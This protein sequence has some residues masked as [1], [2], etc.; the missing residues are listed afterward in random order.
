[1]PSK[2]EEAFMVFISEGDW[3]NAALHEN[4][5]SQK[6]IYETILNSIEEGVTLINSD[7]ICIYCNSAAEKIEGLA[8]E[9]RLGRTLKEIYP[10]YWPSSLQARVIKT[11]TPRL[12]IHQNYTMG[13]RTIEV[14]SNTYPFIFENRM[15][16]AVSIF[17][18]FS[19][20]KKLIEQNIDL[21]YQLS[22]TSGKKNSREKANTSCQFLDIIGQS[23]PMISVIQKARRI[24]GTDSPVLIYG[25]T[26]TGKELFARSIHN[27]GPN[28]E[29]PFL[30]INCAAIPENLL[31][32]LLFGTTKGAF[33]GSMD[34]PGLFEQANG[35]SLFLD[36]IN[37]MP[38]STQSKLLRALQ[39]KRV[40]RLGQKNET[41]I[42]ARVISSCNIN[43]QKAIKTHLIRSDLFY[44]LA[45]VYLEIPPLKDRERDIFMLSDYFVKFFNRKFNKQILSLGPE[46]IKAF[47]EYDWPGNVRQLRHGIESAMNIVPEGAVF[48]EACHIPEYMGLFASQGAQKNTLSS[49]KPVPFKTFGPEPESDPIVHMVK[50]ESI[51]QNL[52][53]KEKEMII[54]SLKQHKGRIT[55]SAKSLGISRQSLQYRL[56]KYGIKNLPAYLKYS[57][58][59]MKP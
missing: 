9:D 44:R 11:Q 35:G 58:R 41:P 56:K 2:N 18:N 3:V 52:Q 32:S 4:I 19:T 27:A 57:E 25:E 53:D 47:R 59:L 33:T 1:M 40:R 5:T 54:K 50:D 26:G 6:K 49:P 31:E 45:V 7:G 46:V 12:N 10:L 14:I 34:K 51:L 23:R 28:P 13:N 42:D 30:A 38:M 8:K 43:P 22:F 37:S 29:G 16:G 17:Q 24:A 39:E 55:Q 21:Q 36:E 15:A 48:I 20:Y